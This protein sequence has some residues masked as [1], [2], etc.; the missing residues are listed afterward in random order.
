MTLLYKGQKQA[1][2]LSN[3]YVGSKILKQCKEMIFMQFRILANAKGERESCDEDGA[4]KGSW[5]AVFS[6]LT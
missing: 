5:V 2:L 1:I 4:S 6:F 3:T